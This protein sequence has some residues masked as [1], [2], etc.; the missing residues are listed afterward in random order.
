VVGDFNYVAEEAWRSS[1]TALSANDRVFRDYISQPGAEYVLP[2]SSQ[3]LIVWTRKGGDAAEAGDAD[4]FGSMLDGAVTIGA[5][6]S[7]WNRTV[8]DFAFSDDGP[9]TGAS[10]PLSDHAWVTFSRAVP[11]LAI[12][13]ETR[14]LS[15]L[16]R[17]DARVKDGY[18]RRVREGG[19]FE[20]L[21]SARGMVH[22]TVVAVQSLRRVAEQAAAEARRRF[23]ERPLETAHRWRRW[24]QEAY[25][26][27]HRGLSPH[28][29][30]GGLFNYHS[31]LWLI[32]ERYAGAGD[33]VCWAKIIRRCRR[34]WTSANRRLVRRQQRDDE[35]LRELALG[36]QQR[37][38][39]RLRELA[40]GIVE[41]KGSKDLAQVA[42]QAWKAIRSPRTSL[43]FDK[44]HP[45]DDVTS[46]PVTAADDPDAFLK[47]VAREGDRLVQGLSSTPPII[48][49]FK[50]FCKVFCPTYETLRGRDGGEW[51]LAKQLFGFHRAR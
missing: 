5:E 32:R 43:A 29:V 40:L 46:T 12:C 7:L 14:P 28:E 47:G 2:I 38:D 17:G 16:P 49:A 4:G 26:A 50:A 39:E 34:C 41:G 1:R 19:A 36:M 9:M 18:C 10:K 48:D 33:D 3:P 20:D 27:R 42:M 37:D 35:R 13:G 25:A 22:A 6:C 8:V 31:R 24:L 23:E 30:N 21:L 45:R 15:A 51:E 44:F 11:K